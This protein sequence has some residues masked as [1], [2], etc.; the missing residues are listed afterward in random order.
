M[1][2]LTT[3]HLAHTPADLPIHIALYTSLHNAP[4]IH[5][6]LLASNPHYNY[7]FID[8]S[9]LLTPTHLL[10]AIYRALNDSFH[11]RLK[12]R[13]VH[14]EI[15]FSLGANNNIAQA[16]R[17][18]G[19]GKETKELVVVKVGGEREE[20]EGFLGERVEGVGVEWCEESL[21]KVRDV[22]RIRK[23]YKLPEQGGKGKARRKKGVEKSGG[24][25][26][27]GTDPEGEMRELEV[28]ILGLMA[29]RGAV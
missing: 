8:A 26:T 4:H 16:L 22:G 12:S 28:A 21:G 5:S 10:A 13:N 17:G 6:Q 2:P 3:L 19:I 14:S 1:F 25:G 24:D 15:V 29:L 9:T 20:V 23:L 7:A 18:F 11:K 27:A